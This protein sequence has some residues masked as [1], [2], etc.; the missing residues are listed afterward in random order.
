LIWWV[1]ITALAI[2]TADAIAIGAGVPGAKPL[3]A[4]LTLAVA[5]A[6]V[7]ALRFAARWQPAQR[8]RDAAPA[9]A[10]EAARDPG[11]SALLLL[12]AACAIGIVV[13]VPITALLV[14]G[15][16]ALAAVA[17]QSRHLVTERSGSV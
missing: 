1:P 6:A 16:L 8:W 14:C 7:V 11:G 2:A 9:A 12:A 13:L 4:L 17:V 15:P 10:R 3:A 5:A